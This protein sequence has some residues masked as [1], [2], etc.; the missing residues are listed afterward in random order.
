MKLVVAI[1]CLNEEEALRSV[2]E[3]IPETIS[4]IDQ[5]VV[6]VIDDGSTDRSVE[7]ATQAGAI[8][9]SHG[10]NRGVGA[11]FH[12]ALDYATAHRFDVMVTIDGDGQFDPHDIPKL[13]EPVIAG[14][15]HLA[16]ASRFLD[17]EAIPNMP[18]IK[19]WGNRRMA[20]LISGLAGRK[21]SD[22]SC[23]FRAYSREAMLHLNLHGRF[24]YTQETLLQ[25]TFK[26]LSIAE[27][28]ARVRYFADRESR[29][30]DSI[31]RYA[32]RTTLII[33]GAYRDYS[34]I[35]F[36]WSLALV[37]F[38]IGAGLGGNLLL[39]YART[40]AFS[41]QIWSG[42]SGAV[43]GLIGFVF[44]VLGIIADMLDRQ[45]TNQ[46]RLLYILKRGAPS[47]REPDPHSGS[48]RE[49]S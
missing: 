38:L 34:P 48:P 16:T 45:R 8:V 6:L 24:T 2:I 17:D 25:L 29:V 49:R 30:A 47:T 32:I 28:P 20:T 35:R 13:I 10:M 37:F 21:F 40:G 42:F 1:P 11:A 31:V 27:V 15:A 33:L 12:T 46:E 7:E 19:R 36:F 14:T 43:L 22:V 9:I 5:R 26:G 41:G 4:G 18:W 23:G 3:A 39:H 44:F